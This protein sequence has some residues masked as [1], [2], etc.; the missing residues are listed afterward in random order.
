MT[1]PQRQA[2]AAKRIRTK[3]PEK[4]LDA[5]ELPPGTLCLKNGWF[6]DGEAWFSEPNLLPFRH[7]QSPVPNTGK[8]RWSFADRKIRMGQI[9][10]P[11]RY[12]ED[13]EDQ[14]PPIR[15]SFRTRLLLSLSC[16]YEDGGRRRTQRNWKSQRDSQ[17]K[18]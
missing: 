2:L 6:S 12:Q 1:Y 13:P 3:A 10:K 15:K 16:P 7:R 9:L 8:R 11:L 17:W 18:P 5:T 4:I 14:I